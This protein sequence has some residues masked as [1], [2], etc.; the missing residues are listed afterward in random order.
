MACIFFM[1]LLTLNFEPLFPEGMQ[2]STFMKIPWGQLAPK[3]SD[4][5]ASKSIFNWWKARKVICQWN[6]SLSLWR[7]QRSQHQALGRD[8]RNTSC[9][10]VYTSFPGLPALNLD[11]FILESM[12]FTSVHCTS[13][14]VLKYVFLVLLI[15]ICHFDC[16]LLP[17]SLHHVVAKS[18]IALKT[19]L[20][21]TSYVLPAIE[22]LHQRYWIISASVNIITWISKLNS[23]WAPNSNSKCAIIDLDNVAFLCVGLIS[24]SQQVATDCNDYTCSLLA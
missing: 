11:L 16:S 20:L 13:F 8:Y 2:G 23:S 1:L 7:P 18:C 14:S 5:V 4:L 9:Q 22:E 12:Q 21:T 24:S 15:K 3:A 10:I 6:K 17:Y 19:N